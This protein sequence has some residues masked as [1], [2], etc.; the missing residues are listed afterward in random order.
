V[1]FSPRKQQMVLYLVGGFEDRHGS[2]LA[3]LGPHQTGK[4]CLYVQR[5]DDVD[6]TA[7]RELILR[8]VRVHRG[9]DQA[10]STGG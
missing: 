4:G 6:Q 3:R 1:G 7:L 5:L 10:D 2:V 8:S 9:V